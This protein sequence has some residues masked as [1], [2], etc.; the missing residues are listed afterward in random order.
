MDISG[1]AAPRPMHPLC[2]NAEFT[3]FSS[4]QALIADAAIP[5]F[6]NVRVQALF[7]GH[8]VSEVSRFL[9]RNLQAVLGDS[10]AMLVTNSD[11]FE[12]TKDHSPL[13]PQEKRRIEQAGYPMTITKMSNTKTQIGVTA[14]VSDLYLTQFYARFGDT[15]LLTCDGV[16]VSAKMAWAAMTSITRT[17]SGASKNAVAAA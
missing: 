17:L 15:I 10:R 13:D 3:A 11:Y 14:A 12:M 9:A 1:A 6:P 7:D 4:I 5:K 2:S 16:S 8:T